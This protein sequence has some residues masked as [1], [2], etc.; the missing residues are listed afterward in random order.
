MTIT[1]E[2][3]PGQNGEIKASL[4]A[5]MK[6]VTRRLT[7]VGRDS[8]WGNLSPEARREKVIEGLSLSQDS[9]R[10][11]GKYKSNVNDIGLVI[12]AYEDGDITTEEIL[13]VAI[14]KQE[15]TEKP[16]KR[17]LALFNR[18]PKR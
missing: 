11:A 8:D 4:L 2:R 17:F 18:S 5:G 9:Y 13:E 6:T 1:P 3:G 15:Q 10:V 12:K 14:P 16:K 7:E